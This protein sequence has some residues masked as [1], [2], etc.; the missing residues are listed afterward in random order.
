MLRHTAHTQP[1]PI[2]ADTMKHQVAIFRFTLGNG[3]SI[4][5]TAL[6]SIWVRACQSPDVSVGRKAGGYPD[7]NRPIYSLYAQPGLEDLSQVERRLRRLFDET[8][9]RASLV[10]MHV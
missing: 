4:S 3:Q 1:T 10:S 9:L 5:P 6:Q 7:N 8:G 2:E